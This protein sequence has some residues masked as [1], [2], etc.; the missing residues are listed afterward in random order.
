[1]VNL[2]CGWYPHTLAAFLQLWLCHL[3]PGVRSQREAFIS[4]RAKTAL[5]CVLFCFEQKACKSFNYAD[6]RIV[7]Y[8]MK[9][10][11]MT[12]IHW[13][14]WKM[15]DTP[16][17]RY[18]EQH[19]NQRTNRRQKMQLDRYISVFFY[20]QVNCN[21]AVMHVIFYP[22][23]EKNAHHPP[24]VEASSASLSR[25]W[26]KVFVRIWPLGALR[27]I[28]IVFDIFHLARKKSQRLRML[29]AKCWAVWIN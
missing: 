26:I 4:S 13:N 5:D 17:I 9:S 11:M 8:T 21:P 1:M 29:W 12:E 3:F 23:M 27:K 19:M 6:Y 25:V 18:L 14:F 22:T 28:S 15:I 16:S 10:R 20:Q 24:R 2:P 7:N